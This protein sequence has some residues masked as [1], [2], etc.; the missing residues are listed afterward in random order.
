M[1]P[2]QSANNVQ[3]L[4]IVNFRIRQ[5]IKCTFYILTI[6]YTCIHI[7]KHADDEIDCDYIRE[8]ILEAINQQQKSTIIG[9]ESQKP[10]ILI[11]YDY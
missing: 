10:Q 3:I 5:F 9:S 1:T 8:D 2:T 4:R 7:V 6:T 11:L